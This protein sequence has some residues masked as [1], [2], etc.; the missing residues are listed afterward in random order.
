MSDGR[1]K[2]YAGPEFYERKLELVM[3]RFG[4]KKDDCE[5]NWDRFGGWVQFRLKGELYRFEH[6]VEKAKAK[7]NKLTYGSDAFAQIVLTLEDLARMQERGI[8]EL[9]TWIAGLKFLP[10]VVE[11]PTFFRQ[12]GFTDLPAST[13]DVRERYR[14][15]AKQLHPDAGGNAEDFQNLQK[16]AEQAVKWFG[17][18]G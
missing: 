1:R 8:Y 4:V 2:Q 6:S 10:P 18:R 17:E 11:V 9:T 12:M 16:A 15:L 13:D 3:E 5:W 7:G 14:T